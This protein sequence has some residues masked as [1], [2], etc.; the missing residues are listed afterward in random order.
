MRCRDGCDRDQGDEEPS[1]VDREVFEAQC[2][3]GV[4][5]DQ[6]NGAEDGPPR[7][8]PAVRAAESHQEQRDEQK[9]HQSD[10]EP[11]RD[12]DERRHATGQ[13]STS[14]DR[15]RAP[16]EDR[17]HERGPGIHEGGTVQAGFPLKVKTGVTDNVSI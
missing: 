13:D 4:R 11:H 12:H 3:Q 17:C 6:R 2:E 10:A 15:R 5:H 16:P 9:D 7:P 14:E 8:M 1:D